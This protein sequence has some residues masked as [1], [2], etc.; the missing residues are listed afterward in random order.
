MQGHISK[1]RIYAKSVA[2]LCTGLVLILAGQGCATLDKD[3]CLVADWQLI[4][5]QDGV[6]GK[7]AAVVSE[8]REDCAKHGVVPDLAGYQSGRDQGLQQYCKPAN[9]YRLGES[10]RAY[11]TLCPSG[12]EDEFRA[13]YDDGREIYL[14]RSRVK[15]TRSQIQ[16]HRQDIENLEQDKGDKLAQ[17]IQEGLTSEQRV[18]L[19]YEIHGIDEEI[20]SVAGEINVLEHDLQHQQAQLDHLRQTRTY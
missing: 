11:A 17:L 2:G 19:L 3:E 8:Y 7:S 4:G 15:S 14:A 5:Y 10:G 12:M 13:A 20:D 18:L 1:A 6:V 16:G 9:G